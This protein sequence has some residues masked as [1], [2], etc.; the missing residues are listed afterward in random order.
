[1]ATSTAPT[2]CQLIDELV[3]EATG[4]DVPPQVAEEARRATTRGVR[5]PS[6]P[7][8]PHTRRRVETYFSAVV[9]RRVVRRSCAPRAAARFVVAS[10]VDDLRSTGRTGADIWD[11]LQRGW[12]QRIP[13]DVL[14][15][16][17]LR[18]CG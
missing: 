7:V 14:E 6:G 2:L 4:R 11:E 18:L 13:G 10:V 9:R 15:E 5:A 12:A 8:T 3:W 16:Y 17:R 1:M